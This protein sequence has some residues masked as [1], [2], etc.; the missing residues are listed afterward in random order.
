MKGTG[1]T[2]PFAPALLAGLLAAVVWMPLRAPSPGEAGGS[3]E[4][5]R[6]QA[7]TAAEERTDAPRFRWP[8][9]GRVT[10]PF[11]V[12]RIFGTEDF[13]RG[14]DIAAPPGTEITAAA[15]G[16]VVFAGEKGSY[17][18][19]VEVDH[20]YGYVTCYAHCSEILV[21][22]GERV[23]Q[24]EVVALV[25]ATGRATGAHCHFEVRWRGVAVDAEGVM[26]QE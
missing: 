26:E 24:G 4:E 22:E 1:K 8:C 11:G 14:T 25:G 6:V 10:S 18:N 9:A 2:G 13:H 5:V 23:E 17:G 7:V 15:G 16:T 21:E 12:R 19:L 20:G 3:P